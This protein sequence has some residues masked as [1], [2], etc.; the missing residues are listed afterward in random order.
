MSKITRQDT[1]GVKPLLGTGELGYDNYHA[2]GDAGRVYVGTGTEN[3]GLA[4]KTEVITVDGKADAHIARVDNPH[5]VTKAQV[6]LGNV[7]NTSDINKP[8]STAT[9][10][11]LNTKQGVLVSGTNI[12]TIE[13]QSLVGS[14]N[15]D[16]TKSDV[17]LDNVDNTADST[18]NVLSATKWTTSR[19]ITIGNSTKS[20][21]G[22]G[23]V[24][25]TLA[26]IGA[27][28]TNSPAFTGTPTATTAAVGTNTTQLATTAFVNA[29]IANDAIP[30]ITSTDNAIVRFDGTTGTVQDSGVNIDDNSVLSIGEYYG[31][32]QTGRKVLMVGDAAVSCFPSG[33][34]VL[35]SSNMRYD[36]A[37]KFI[38][39]GS[40]GI[41]SQSYGR[42]IWSN[43][44]NG[45]ADET[46]TPIQHLILD[47]SG[48]LLLT[49]GTGALGYGT[50]AGGT[51]TQLTSKSTAVT[52]NKP[53]G[54]I[55]MSNAALVAGAIATFQVNNSLVNI[56]SNVV[57][58][59][60][61]GNTE[62]IYSL[63]VEKI[64]DGFFTLT[65]RNNSTSSYSQP[66]VIKFD[67][68]QG[69]IA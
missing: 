42:H 53:S 66:I 37:Y 27:I 63:E 12:K 7:D 14:G 5:S 41:Y 11:A 19:N 58:N 47:T 52:L 29:E 9:Q 45:L 3:I 51:V 43:S 35:I 61:A 21:D 4:K 15:I 30:R 25:W 20:V 38:T 34:Q 18:K 55:T 6:G 10:T 17:G 36:G 13:G 46:T 68:I 69:A 56:T 8:I 60:R 24:A 1:N 2:G 44:I 22:A 31:S 62:G 26:E 28:G 48:N 59:I 32:W 49:S 16:L 40:M 57:V 64:G 33:Q 54:Q 23:N 65:I 39:N 50:G 67:L